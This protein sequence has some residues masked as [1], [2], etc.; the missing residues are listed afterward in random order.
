MEK[1]YPIDI[2][3]IKNIG[4][5]EWLENYYVPVTGK[6]FNAIYN[7]VKTAY[8]VLLKKNQDNVVKSIAL[9]NFPLTKTVSMYVFELLTLSRL[10][11]YGYKFIVGEEKE[12]IPDNI[13]MG[14][15]F[16]SESNQ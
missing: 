8:L 16:F 11:V 9:S 14:H 4:V 15:S 12:E 6:E 7:E 13:S 10:K 5:E 1:I 2:A 3:G